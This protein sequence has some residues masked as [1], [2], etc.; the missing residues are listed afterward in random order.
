[1]SEINDDEGLKAVYFARRYL[2][3]STLVSVVNIA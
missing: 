2:T 3:G 1:M